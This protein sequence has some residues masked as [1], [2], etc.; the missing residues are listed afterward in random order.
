MTDT[1]KS[2]V[3]VKRRPIS[4]RTSVD[5]HSIG[6]FTMQLALILALA[7]LAFAKV[8]PMYATMLQPFTVF[9]SISG[10][11]AVLRRQRLSAHQCVLLVRETSAKGGAA[12]IRPVGQ[13]DA[14]ARSVLRRRA[15]PGGAARGDPPPTTRHEARRRVIYCAA[16]ST[17]MSDVYN[18]ATQSFVYATFV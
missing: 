14:R 15:V 18:C 11:H 9:Q 16:V 5:P 2:K 1:N 12:F 13:G 8:Y 4:K 3:L 6:T 10:H 17:P 7:A